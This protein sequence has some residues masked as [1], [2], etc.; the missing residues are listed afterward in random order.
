MINGPNAIY[1]TT[2]IE[3]CEFNILFGILKVY[4]YVYIYVI[5]CDSILRLY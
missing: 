1:N 2:Y 4:I 3:K 5:A